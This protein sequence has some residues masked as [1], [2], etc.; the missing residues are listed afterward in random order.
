MQMTGKA[1][2]A[3]DTRLQPELAALIQVLREADIEIE[4]PEQVQRYLQQY[5]E[6][7]GA[8]QVMS[9]A[10]R[11]EFPDAQLLLTVSQDPEVEDQ[12]LSLVVRRDSYDGTEVGRIERIHEAYRH[13]NKGM[14]WFLLLTDFQPPTRK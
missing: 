2:I 11:S 14:G 7:I 5:P 9:M 12:F 13:Q 8:V 3:I 10:A 1:D 6:L 4:E